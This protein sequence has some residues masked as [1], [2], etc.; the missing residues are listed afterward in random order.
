[1][2]EE[3]TKSFE[4][5]FKEFIALM[6]G[7]T[8]LT[9]L[10]DQCKAMTAAVKEVMR[11][12]THLWCKWH[13]LCHAPEELGPVYRVNGEFREEFHY[14][15]NEMLT[16]DEFEM[17]WADLLDR[18]NLHGHPFMEKTY[19]KRKKWAKPWVKDKFCAR[20]A[21]TQRSESANSILKKVIPSNAPMNR[22]VD[23][24]RKLLFMRTSAEQK[25]E[26]KTKKFK[27]CKKWRPAIEQHAFSV[28]TQ[29][30]FE[31]FS[32]QVEKAAQ[33]SVVQSATSEYNVV[34]NNASQR[35]KW[36]RVM[37]TVRIED[38]GSRYSCECGMYEHFGIL[39]CHAIK[40]LIHTGVTRIPEAHI[41]KRWTRTAR[42]FVYLDDISSGPVSS[43]LSQNL[44]LVNALEVVRRD[45]QASDILARHLSNARKEIDRLQEH[46]SKNP[47]YDDVSGTE[48]DNADGYQTDCVSEAEG[49]GGNM[50][51]ATGSSAYMSDHDIRQLQA[52]EVIRQPGR[53]RANRFPSMFEKKRKG[54]KL[55]PR[56]QRKKKAR[57]TR[58]AN[59][60]T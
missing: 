16:V 35:K 15:I 26:H 36:A 50:Y 46:R 53:P 52:P 23:Q 24:Y 48:D 54:S 37:F 33:Y 56:T 3:T 18:Y 39:C 34:H 47:G 6:G 17:A 51:G 29:K 57:T 1:M 58:L 28:C 45:S 8:P 31:L 12:T 30:T 27:L 21:S 19:N 10:M 2:R 20:M 44:V 14:I 32:E 9:I 59:K 55:K 42:D 41:M 5:V 60:N 22:F 49:L 38:D 13:V 4:W 40:L 25:A 11:G 7:T 43:Q